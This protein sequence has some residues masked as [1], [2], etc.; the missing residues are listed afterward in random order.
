MGEPALRLSG[1][2]KRYGGVTAVDMVTLEIPAGEIHAIIGPNGAGKST[3]VALISG[4]IPS[5]SGTVSYFGRDVTS[6]PFDARVRIGIARSF[7]ITSL[8]PDFTALEN[9]ALAVQARSGHAFRFWSDAS[10]DTKLTEPAH[11]YLARVGLGTRHDVPAT[12]L[13]HGEQR[14]LEIAVALAT[15]PQ[16]LLLDEPTAG[17][18]P[19]D[20]RAM[21]TLIE[22]LRGR[23][24]VVLVE[25]D[26]DAVFSLANRITVLESGRILATGTPGDI[27]SDAAVR[28]AYLGEEAP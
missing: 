20:S 19:D 12:M 9:V 7:Q 13:S 21:V 22:S 27:R 14:Q 25:H 5:D 26:M 4:Q 1:L 18:G 8:I 23:C 3:L 2:G 6:L 11:R 16:L 24:T 15:E 10:R 17:M 28:L